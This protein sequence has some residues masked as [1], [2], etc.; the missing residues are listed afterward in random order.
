MLSP[1]HYFSPTLVRTLST[2][3]QVEQSTREHSGNRRVQCDTAVQASHLQ[4]KNNT[5]ALTGKDGQQEEEGGVS[6]FYVP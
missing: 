4:G 6:G 2:M 1:S 5:E 3:I